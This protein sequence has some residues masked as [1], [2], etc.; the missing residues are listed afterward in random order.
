MANYEFEALDAA[1]LGEQLVPWLGMDCAAAEREVVQIA[2]ELANQAVLQGN[3]YGEFHG[4]SFA[5]R[6][7]HFERTAWVLLQVRLR[8]RLVACVRTHD[9]RLEPTTAWCDP[10][11][12]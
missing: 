12:S 3:A 11:A 8:G 1:A 9:L 7:H 4:V 6:C 5:A 10:E 2:L